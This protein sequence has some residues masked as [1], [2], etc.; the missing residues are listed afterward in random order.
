MAEDTVLLAGDIH[1]IGGDEQGKLFTARL[2]RV[3]TDKVYEVR[4]SELQL[5]PSQRSLIEMGAPVRCRFEPGEKPEDGLEALARARVRIGDAPA[6]ED[7]FA[8][9]NRARVSVA[10]N[11]PSEQ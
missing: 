5:P 9:I 1:E 2:E 8:A 7:L 6:R 11:R 3:G 4:F 10:T